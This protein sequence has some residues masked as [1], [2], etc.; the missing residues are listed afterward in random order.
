M[1]AARGEHVFRDKPA[2][3][4]IKLAIEQYG[5]EAH[6]AEAI[7]VTRE[8]LLLWKSGEE[9]APPEICQAI[10]DVLKGEGRGS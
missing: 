5:S 1:I 3:N 10:A 8:Q 4:F 7:G 9:E 6:L 2:R